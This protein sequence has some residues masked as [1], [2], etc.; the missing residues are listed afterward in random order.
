M[1]KIISPFLFV[2]LPERINLWPNW[3]GV[4]QIKVPL[5]FLLEVYEAVLLKII[6]DP[7]FFWKAS[8]ESLQ[9]CV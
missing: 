5:S 1:L 9:F 4:L 3:N 7:D 6:K 2:V 8:K